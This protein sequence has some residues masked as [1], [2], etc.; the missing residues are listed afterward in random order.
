MCDPIF[1]IDGHTIPPGTSVGADIY[2][3]HH[4]PGYFPDPFPYKPERWIDN[5]IDTVSSK[6][7]HAARGRDTDNSPSDTLIRNPAFIPFSLGARGCAG[8]ALAYTEVGMAMARTLWYF[9]FEFAEPIPQEQ[10]F[11]LSDVFT[12]SH[13]GPYLKFT[14]SAG[15]Y[16]HELADFAFENSIFRT[17]KL[18]LGFDQRGGASGNHH[19]VDQEV[20][21]INPVSSRHQGPHSN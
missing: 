17:M 9:G 1:T 12:S 18:S 5:R 4:N 10:E 14:P 2:A 16:C 6:T 21:I 20:A 3:L 19:L 13:R 7:A 11:R 15:G 8:R